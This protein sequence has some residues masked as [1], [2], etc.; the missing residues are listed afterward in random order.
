MRIDLTS[1]SVA[2]PNVERAASSQ[3]AKASTEQSRQA[4]IFESNPE[5]GKLTAAALDSPEVRSDK[6]QA[7]QLQIRAGTYHVPAAQVAGSML[8]Q[9]RVRPA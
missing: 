1:A 5:V 7:L 9:M 3:T 4:Q 6:I 8:E 2:E